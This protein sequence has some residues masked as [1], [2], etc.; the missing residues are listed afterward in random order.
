MAGE[1]IA[2]LRRYVAGLREQGPR[3][4]RESLLVAVRRQAEKFT[5]FYGID[6]KVVADSD[7][8]V[9]GGDVP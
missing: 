5:E 7:V 4:A 3:T 9:K 1:G 8:R 6:V 2:E